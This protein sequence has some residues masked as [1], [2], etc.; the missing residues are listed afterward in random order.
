MRPLGNGS[1]AKLHGRLG[2]LFAAGDTERGGATGEWQFHVVN[3]AR[4]TTEIVPNVTL[5]N[6]V[7]VDLTDPKDL[8]AALA[9]AP[10]PDVGFRGV[11]NG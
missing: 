10:S 2:I 3:S 6:L 8:A 5:T 11:P 1:W 7:Q 9:E 4:E